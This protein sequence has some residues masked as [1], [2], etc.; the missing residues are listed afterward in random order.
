MNKPGFTL[1]ELMIVVAII[2]IIIAIAVPSLFRSRMAA[3]EAAAAAA[4]KAFSE[5]EEIYRRTDYDRDGILEYA[6]RLSGNNSLLEITA[7]AG[8]LGMIDKVFGA[9][10]GNPGAVT[11]KAGYVFRVLTR[12][13]VNAIGGARNYISPSGN[14]VYGYG[15]SAVPDAWDGTGR[16]AYITN[17]NGTI[18]CRDFGNSTH[19]MIFNPDTN[20]AV[21][22]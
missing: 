20:W 9:A 16:N 8:D 18:Y 19:Q 22:E 17:N 15:I 7:G 14:M 1:I 5:A 11:S 13:G 2:A 12:Q 6:Q 4:C 3:N 21:V 10:E